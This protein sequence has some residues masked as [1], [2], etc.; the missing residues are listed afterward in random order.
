MADGDIRIK[1]P[2]IRDVNQIGSSFVF[3][4]RVMDDIHFKAELGR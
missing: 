4:P 3:P 1:K 2:L